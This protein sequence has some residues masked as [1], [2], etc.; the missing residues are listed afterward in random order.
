MVII[1]IIGNPLFL[2][3]ARMQVRQSSHS[4]RHIVSTGTTRLILQQSQL[5]DNITVLQKKPIWCAINDLSSGGSPQF[6]SWHRCCHSTGSSVR[7]SQAV[8]ARHGRRKYQAITHLPPRNR[9]L[10][11]I[12]PLFYNRSFISF[13]LFKGWQN[14]K[15]T[16]LL[17]ASTSKNWILTNPF[18]NVRQKS[19]A[20]CCSLCQARPQSMLLTHGPLVFVEMM[21][22]V[23]FSW[24]RWHACFFNTRNYCLPSAWLPLCKR[25]MGRRRPTQHVGT[26]TYWMCQHRFIQVCDA[27]VRAFGHF[28]DIV[29]LSH[30]CVP[31]VNE[32]KGETCTG[33]LVH[34]EHCRPT[35]LVGC[36]RT[37]SVLWWIELGALLTRVCSTG[38]GY[39]AGTFVGHCVCSCSRSPFVV[40]SYNGVALLYLC[41]GCHKRDGWNCHKLFVILCSK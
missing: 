28:N 41:C 19:S 18:T 21:G 5:E 6:S 4:E 26:A 40:A 23:G 13:V 34:G 31:L 11:L 25:W 29:L 1:A 30:R 17:L 3:K 12:H 33:V 14:Q 10:F 7:S 36:R 15:Y 27:R 22:P 39:R 20:D 35:L 32:T 16:F 8:V 37:I 2:I 24:R 9:C 38:A